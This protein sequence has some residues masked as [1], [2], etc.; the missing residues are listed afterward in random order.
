MQ[1]LVPVLLKTGGIVSL[2]VRSF[3]TNSTVFFFN[4]LIDTL[5]DAYNFS[6]QPVKW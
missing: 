3:K 5:N 6:T 1:T 4:Q 2:N